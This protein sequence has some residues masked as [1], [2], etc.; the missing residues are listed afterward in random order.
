MHSLF[1]SSPL[2]RLVV[3]LGVF[4]FA[5]WAL[6]VAAFFAWSPSRGV[7]MAADRKSTRLNS[8]H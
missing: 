7:A 4:T 1:W 5:F 8:S 3:G 6:A 2:G